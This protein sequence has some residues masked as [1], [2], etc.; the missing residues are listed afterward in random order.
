MSM[1]SPS[2]DNIVACWSCRGPV[3]EAAL[4][5][6]TCGAVQP[7]GAR[8]HFARLG[9]PRGFEIDAADLDRRY[10]AFQ[11]NLHPDRFARRTAKERAIAESQSASLNQAY[12][13]LKD[14]LDRAAYLL[15]LAGRR[16]AAA[17]AMTVDDEELLTEAMEN[18]EALMEAED[19]ETVD[20]LSA[21]SLAA[22]VRYLAGIAA[23]FAREDL[24][25]AD[26]LTTR[27]RYWRKLGEE[28]RAKRRLLESGAS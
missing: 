1:M 22:A 9:L 15:Q 16:S 13:T 18:R 2:D 7:P 12:E 20:A 6:H 3:A 25:E 21:R 14:P 11:R 8:D 17:T 4:F 10:F 26:R 23:A 28:A 5:C 27:L 24:D 19:V